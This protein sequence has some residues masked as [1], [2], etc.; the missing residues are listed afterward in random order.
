MRIPGI[1]HRS[2][3]PRHG[4]SDADRRRL[5]R[6]GHIR[7]IGT[8][9]ATSQAPD[10]LLPILELGSRATCLTAA[11]HH[12]LWVPL[13]SGT[14]VYRPR[15]KGLEARATDLVH[16]GS[17][18]RS[19]P[20]TDPVAELPLALEHAARCV[21]V[22]DAAILFESALHR[23]K[24]SMRS[25]LHCVAHLPRVLR[26]QLSHLSPLAESGTETAVRWWLESLR[27]V[28]IPQVQ[29][30]GVGRVDLKL[31]KSWIIECDSVKYHDNDEQF[32]RDRARDLRLRARGYVVTRLTWE[33]V[34]LDWSNTKE[35]LL[36]ILRR[37]DHRRE[38]PR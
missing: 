11:E 32:H 21:S 35:Q 31:G 33:Q 34:F 26:A 36:T 25:V 1:A 27:V 2:D 6:H 13:H 17:G 15:G 23:K 28:V 8:W 4:I 10:G 9:Y 20:D 29:I 7:R 24:L 22:P 19:W 37:R 18:L 16:H 12:D 30:P 38:L 5:L 14:H 3:L